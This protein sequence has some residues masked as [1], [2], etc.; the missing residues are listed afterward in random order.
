MKETII[1]IV[2]AAAA[3]V[4]VVVVGKRKSRT[5]RSFQKSKHIP[6]THILYFA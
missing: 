1:I 3:V 5:E 2:V 4:N 6:E